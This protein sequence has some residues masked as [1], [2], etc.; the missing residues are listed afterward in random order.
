[1]TASTGLGV[2]FHDEALLVV[3]KPSGLLVHNGWAREAVVALDLAREIA[4]RYV[5]PVHRLDR[6]ASGVLVFT[7]SP[8][9]CRVVQQHWREPTTRKTYLALVRGVAPSDILIDHPLANDKGKPKRPAITRVRRLA[10]S[11]RYS[12]IEAVPR[13][14]R[15]HQIRRHLRHISHPL[16]GDV[17][18]GKR[19]HNHGV[20]DAYGLERLGLH[21]LSLEF[22]HPSTGQRLVC[23]APVPD[24]FAEP[25]GHMGLG[26]PLEGLEAG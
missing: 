13:T 7:L 20:R 6:S 21:A 1:M 25:L 8:E 22:L 24:D 5:Y 4:G 15:L 23:R 2:L 10:A 19:E 17:R 14:G 11:G 18:Y 9:S 3:N 12:L 16:I 26:G